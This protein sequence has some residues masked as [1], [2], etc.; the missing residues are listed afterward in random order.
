MTTNGENGGAFNIT[1]ALKSLQREDVSPKKMNGARFKAQALK[2]LFI[3]L[4]C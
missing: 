2:M 4:L 1:F 3:G